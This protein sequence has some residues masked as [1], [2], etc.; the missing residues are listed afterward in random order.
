MTKNMTLRLPSEQA[1]ELE[2]VARADGVS[3]SDAV[4]QAIVEHID[5]RR[6]DKKF[7]A[8][9]RRIIEEDREVLERLAE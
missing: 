6:Q 5:R 3:V 4:R 7:K 8:R 2:A 1:A 9:L